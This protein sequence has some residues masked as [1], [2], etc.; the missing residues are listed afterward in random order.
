M[1]KNF[2]I[3]TILLCI[4]VAVSIV[5]KPLPIDD[6]LDARIL[7]FPLQLA[8]YSG[9]DITLSQQV[10]DILETKNVIMRA[11]EKQGYPRVLFYLIFS[12]QTHKTSDP[13]ENCVQG[14]GGVILDKSKRQINAGG[15]SLT[16]NRLLVEQDGK[17]ELYFYW[18]I[19]GNEFTDSY[20]VQRVKLMLAYL[21]RAPLS[22]GQIRISTEIS[23]G[24]EPQAVRR[25]EQFI[26]GLLPDLLGLLS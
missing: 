11:Y 24:D 19:A 1:D 4:G 22:G 21:K 13:P 15:R 10:Y 26:E 14:D 3:L 5:L 16:V 2:I 25:L 8:G 20:V 23:D 9:T 7:K 17:K 18:F 6:S 12:K